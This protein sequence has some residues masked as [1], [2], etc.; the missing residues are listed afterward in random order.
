M[1]FNAGGK[2]EDN[3]ELIEEELMQEEEVDEEIF[4]KNP[5]K[6]VLFSG[7]LQW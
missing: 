4:G 2:N 7:L 1:K 3:E 5:A 6:K